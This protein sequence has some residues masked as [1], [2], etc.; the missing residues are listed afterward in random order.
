MNLLYT[1]NTVAAKLFAY[2]PTS[3]T[4]SHFWE[5]ICYWVKTILYL[6]GKAPSRTCA[7]FLLQKHWARPL[8]AD[9]LCQEDCKILKTSSRLQKKFFGTREIFKTLDASYG[10]LKKRC[11]WG[12]GDFAVIFFIIWDD[13]FW[14]QHFMDFDVGCKINFDFFIVLQWHF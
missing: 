2:S 8:W 6:Y 12:G 5:N 1:P 9:P 4:F 13:S 3:D 7:F 11:P 10:E 14:K